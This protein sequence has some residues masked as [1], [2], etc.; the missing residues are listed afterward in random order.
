MGSER[1]T[2][3]PAT[4]AKLDELLAA[5]REYSEPRRAGEEWKHVYRLLQK[6]EAPAGRATA[7]V[8]MRDVI[9]LA[10]MIEQLRAPAPP[11]ADVPDE[12]TCR[13][14]LQA[15]RRRL[16]LTILDEESKL[17]RGPLS[18]G[19]GGGVRAVVPPAEWPQ[20]VWQELVRQG[21]LRPI[22]HGLY[23]LAG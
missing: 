16:E 9:G 2:A 5:I 21:K 13:K 7:I 22:G 8:G 6:T 1:M 14:A 23:E 15:F 4:L 17:G 10:E 19:A 12:D 20:A 18:K 3:E 11:P